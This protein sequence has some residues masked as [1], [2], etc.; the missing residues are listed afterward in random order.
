MSNEE[1]SQHAPALLELLTDKL[2]RD[3]GRQRFQ[4]GYNLNK[5]QAF[6]LVSDQRIYQ[7][8]SQVTSQMGRSKAGDVNLCQISDLIPEGG[9]VER[10]AQRITQDNLSEK[11]VESIAKALAES[12]SNDSAGSSRSSR[13]RR[14]LRILNAPEKIISATLIPEITRSANKIQRIVVGNVKMKGSIFLTTS[15]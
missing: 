11:D 9:T 15:R 12:A 2:K 3:K 5:E 14:E 4:K 10:I 13:L 1:L 7:S 8:R 6:I